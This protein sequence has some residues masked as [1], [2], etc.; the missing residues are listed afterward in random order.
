MAFCAVNSILSQYDP[1]I[2]INPLRCN[3]WSCSECRDKRQG[4]LKSEAYRGRPNAF[5]TLTV[6]PAIGTGPDHRARDLVEAWR[7]VRRRAK[8]KWG[9][10]RLPFLAV[11]EETKAG[12]PHLHILCRLKWIPQ[13]W[14]SDQMK[15]EIG[16]PI[17]DIRRVES[18][19]KVASY[20]A[21]Y[22]GK[23]PEKFG[24]CKRYWRSLDYLVEPRREYTD[25]LGPAKSRWFERGLPDDIA[26]R[27]SSK[28]YRLEVFDLAEGKEY[29]LADELPL[30]KLVRE[31]PEKEACLGQEGLFSDDLIFGSS[32]SPGA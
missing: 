8:E 28:L 14:L 9:N 19:K 5:I 1:G 31:E 13:D 17:V 12:E 26:K 18:K 24:G 22:V 21:K 6:N 30:L 23:N 10:V 32:P 27:F 20:V 11:F 2:K 3:R 29:W 25:P 16:A 7:K 15:A 4:R